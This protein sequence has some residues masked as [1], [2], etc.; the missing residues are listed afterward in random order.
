MLNS[1]FELLSPCWGVRQERASTTLSQ[2]PHPL[3]QP[4]LPS[5]LR[6]RRQFQHPFP[7]F[8]QGEFRLGAGNRRVGEFAGEQGAGVVGQ[9]QGSVGEFRVL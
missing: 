8:Q 4:T 2:F 9:D 3:P 5:R 6:P 1:W 7:S